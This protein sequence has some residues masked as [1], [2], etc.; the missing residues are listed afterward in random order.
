MS[1]QTVGVA[2]FCCI[3]GKNPF[4]DTQGV[5]HGVVEL[6]RENWAH[7]T[8]IARDLVNELICIDP[9]HR[10]SATAA[11][12]KPW[13]TSEPEHL[14]IFDLTLAKTR[15]ENRLPDSKLEAPVRVPHPG[16]KFASLESAVPPEALGAAQAAIAFS[17]AVAGIRPP[18]VASD[19]TTEEGSLSGKEFGDLY[20]ILGSGG[21]LSECVHQQSEK[22]YLFRNVSVKQPTAMLDAISFQD[23]IGILRE[24][25]SS[26]FTIN[27]HDS[28]HGESEATMVYR[29]VDLEQSLLKHMDRNGATRQDQVKDI[30]R[31]LLRAIAHCHE[32]RIAI[33]GLAVETIILKDA[34]W[35][36][37]LVDLSHAKK[38]LHKN[39]LR[40]HCGRLQYTAPE[41][42][43][44][45]P[46]YDVSCD[47][48]SAG[49]ILYYLL[50]TA[51]PFDGQET[52]ACI[53]YGVYDSE[54]LPK[55]GGTKR[56]IRSLLNR[57][58]T[59]RISAKRALQDPWMKG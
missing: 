13:T 14:S 47:M 53:R 39:S 51:L 27:L 30:F 17:Q 35:N 33:R 32:R 38:V 29:S 7:V 57:H 56:M 6:K 24:L 41:V 49:V 52:A 31:Q 20:D 55:K 10:T 11:L 21:F 16:N 23:E 50:T 43:C 37:T 28:F 42:L 8:K 19:P 4:R 5:L 15:I 54:P 3:S 2:A 9:R 1:A 22:K 59:E 34:S 36:V 48:W 45:R 18:S 46:R 26:P 44:Y 58:P 40:T 12:H 25:E